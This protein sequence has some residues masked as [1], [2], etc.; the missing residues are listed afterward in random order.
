[1]SFSILI[2]TKY[3]NNGASI[4]SIVTKFSTE[5]AAI[6]AI[7]SIRADQRNNARSFEQVAIPLFVP[8]S[9]TAPKQ[10]GEILSC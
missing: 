2:T 10:T 6:A 9:T 5:F 3:F 4:H 8:K 7:N 1:M